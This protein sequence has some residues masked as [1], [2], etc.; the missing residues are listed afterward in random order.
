M[1]SPEEEEQVV[2]EVFRVL[3]ETECLVIL[4][5]D[6]SGEPVY[7][8]TEKCRDLFPEFYAAHKAE[9]NQTANELWQKGVISINFTDDSESIMVTPANYAELKRVYKDLTDEQIDF[10]NALRSN[11]N[12]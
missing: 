2:E 9:I 7:R 5:Y 1:L 10:M 11:K 6:D 3:L 8:V 12:D 4:R